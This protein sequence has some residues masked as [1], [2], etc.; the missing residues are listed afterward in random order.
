MSLPFCLSEANPRL[1]GDPVDTLTGAVFDGKLDFRLTG[2]LEFW[3]YRH[4]DSSQ[5]HRRFALGRGQ[6]HDFDRSLRFDVDGITYEG[7]VGRAFGFSPLVNDGDECAAH[8]LTLRRL[9]L[10]RYELLRHGE[11]RMEF[12]F[13]DPNDRARLTRLSEGPHQILFRYAPDGRLHRIVDSA[14]RNIRVVEDPNGQVISLTLVNERDEPQQLLVAYQYDES[15]NLI[16]TTNASGHGYRF[17]YDEDN[18]LVRRTGRKGF[19]FF[20]AYDSEGRCIKATGDNRLYEASLNYEIPGRVTKVTRADGGVWTYFFDEA[21][22]LSQVLDPLGGVKQFVRDESGRV[23]KEVDPNGNVTRLVYDASGAAVAK[24]TPLGHRVRLP[25]NPNDPDPLLHRVAA[26]PVEYEFGR[27]LDVNSITLPT[28]ADLAALRLPIEAQRLVVTCPPADDDLPPVKSES[29]LI[30]TRSASEAPSLSSAP[31]AFDVR[32]LG[33]KWWPQL[34]QGRV[35]NDLGKLVAQRDEF[36]RVR[37]WTYDA[38]G[39]LETHTDFDGGKWLYEY[40]AWHFRLGETTPAGATVKLTYTE[41]GE[42]AT[43]TDAGGTLSEYSYDLNDHLVE[44]RRHGA[45]RDKYVRDATGNLL[46]KHASD[47]RLLLKFEI[48]AG[49][50]PVKRTLASGDEHTFQYDESGRYLLAATKKDSVEFAYDAMGNRCSEKRNG[51]G[52]EH[53]YQGW[54]KPAE[55]KFFDRFVIRYEWPDERTLVITDPGGKKHRV[56]FHPHGIVERQYSNGSR[57]VAQYDGQGRCLFKSAQR[58]RGSVWNR[59]YEWSGEGELRRVR[60]NLHGELQH[61]YDAAHRLQRRILPGGQVEDYVIDRADNLI[62]QPGFSATLRDG[63]R[64]ESVNGFR[65]EYNDRNHISLR[66]TPDGPFRYSYDSR[67]QLVR[68]ETP[69]GV[70]EAMY[71]ALGRRTRKTWAGQTTEFY[72]HT[73]QLI[74]ELHSDGRLRLYLYSDPLAL[75]PILFLDYD[76]FEALPESCRRYH[77][78]TD[79]IGTPLLIQDDSGAEVWQAQ[80]APYGSATV[81]TNSEI[82]FSLRFPGHYLDA[83]FDLHYNRFRCFAPTLG[84]Y[85]Q[86]DPWGI[87]GGP[88]LYGYRANSLLEVDARGLGDESQPGGKPAKEG[89]EDCEDNR[90]LHERVGW[91]DEHGELKKVIGDGSVDR[92]HQP[93]K[94]AIKKAIAEDINRRVAAGEM[95]EPNAAQMKKINDEI[96]KQALSV[97]VDKDVHKEGPTHGNKNK[98]QSEIDKHDLGA[99]AARDA[100][101]MVANAK[102]HDP[103]NLPAYEAAADKIKQQTHESIMDKHRSIV[104]DVMKPD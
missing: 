17:A 40:G 74:A 64:L 81:A 27:L 19:N 33:M 79:Q 71:D 78:F 8:G 48:G 12:E 4:Y 24:I 2:P 45:V 73:D 69:R 49:N 98:A 67:D 13:H 62:R 16:A 5:S 38:S 93:S 9:S 36:G 97:V 60:D 82:E 31:T 35:F 39:N 80:I 52:V 21:G 84:R 14:G 56:L 42:V 55:S 58:A 6:T 41:Q 96:D 92:D 99:A 66:E 29:S 61:E 89:G 37:E 11:S 72:W 1:V 46:A 76:S 91:T 7:P 44:V 88:N 102:K 22:G 50:L 30:P 26:N 103:D 23:T 3:W 25:E 68:V 70:W 10:W 86:S 75:T 32:P 15:G 51:L 95:E 63:N 18:R 43:C 85:L 53:L 100:D 87:S 59:R 90:P 34:E 28:A 57:E 94:A 104:D 20:Y 65:I 83:E 101:A 47:G 77:V 54:R